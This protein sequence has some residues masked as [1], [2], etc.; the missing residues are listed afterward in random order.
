MRDTYQGFDLQLTERCDPLRIEKNNRWRQ[1]VTD[2]ALFSREFLELDPHP[3]QIQWLTNSIKSQNLLVTGNRWGKS[4]VQ[5][6]K[7]LHRAIF[8]IRDRSFDHIPQVP[9]AQCF[10]HS[11]SGE[12]HLPQLSRV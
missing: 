12:Y 3:G 9:G 6:A 1:A 11:G 2:P 10:D 8:R 5:A 4:T 7:I